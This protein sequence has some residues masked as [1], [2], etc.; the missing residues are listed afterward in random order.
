MGCSRPALYFWS[1]EEPTVALQIPKTE[2]NCVSRSVN[3][4]IGGP[5]TQAFTSWKHFSAT[6]VHWNGLCFVNYGIEYGSKELEASSRG[7]DNLCRTMK[8]DK[9][10][11]KLL[12]CICSPLVFTDIIHF[13][14]T[15]DHMSA[16]SVFLL[17][18]SIHAARSL[19][20]SD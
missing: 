3:A 12:F 9:C 16:K 17:W 14:I 2:T 1:I 4:G 7:A 6:S 19:A 10:S 15:I 8:E 13:A 11:W 20:E 18:R 5:V